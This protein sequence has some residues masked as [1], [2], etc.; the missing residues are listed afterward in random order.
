[1]CGDNIRMRLKGVE[2]DEISPGFVLCS[3]K[4][5]VK[6]TTT[7][8][9]QLAILDHKNI[10]CAG[11]TAVLHIHSAA[12]EIS[13]SALLH[14]IDKKTGKKTRKP[15]QFVKQGQKAI[16]RIETAGPI[17][18]ETFEKLPQLGRFTLR[19]EGKTVAIGKV[20]KVIEPL[21]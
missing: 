18:I 5:P 3:K 9:A 12:E 14:L 13:I 4:N 15:P 10:I 11:Y 7:F 8:E 2:E 21:E 6:T 16:A 19:D 17:C 20:T 1:M